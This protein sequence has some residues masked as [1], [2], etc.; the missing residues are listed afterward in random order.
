MRRTAF[1]FFFFLHFPP[2]DIVVFVSFRFTLPFFLFFFC[3]SLEFSLLPQE[4]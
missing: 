3:L 2:L 1:V 4:Q